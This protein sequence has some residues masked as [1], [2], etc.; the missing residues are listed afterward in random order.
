MKRTLLI[1]AF[2][3]AVA[4]TASFGFGRIEVTTRPVYDDQRDQQWVQSQ[5]NQQAR[6]QWQRA[7][8]Q[9]DGRRRM[10]R[11]EQQ[12]SYEWW[13]RIHIGDYDR[14]RN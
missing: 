5:R 1:A 6:E 4:A 8:W 10:Q 12:V 11:H 13:L 3:L 2:A 9:R 14:N 7:E